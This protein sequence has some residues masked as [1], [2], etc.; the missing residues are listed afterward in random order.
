L[1][2]FLIT[3]EN[4]IIGWNEFLAALLLTSSEFIIAASF[5][6]VTDYPFSLGWSEGNRMWDYS[7]LFAKHLYDIPPGK[8]A[9]ALLDVGRQFIGGAPFIFPRITIQME[10]AWLAATIIIPY[11]LLG[12]AAFHFDRR[13]FKVWFLA[14][15]W[16]LIFLKQGPIHPPLV[17][18]A[19]MVALLWK[20]PLW[21]ALPLIVVT[22]Y[23]AW[24]SRFTWLFAPGMWI[25]MLELADAALQNK[26]LDKSAWTRALSL[27]LVGMAAGWLGPQFI[28]IIPESPINT[29]V[30]LETT[31]EMATIQ[32]LLWYR[33]LPN[34][35]YGVGIIVGLL[36]ATLPLIAILFHL[37]RT[38]KW[39]INTW[40][41][42]AIIAPLSAFL[43]V[44][45]IVSA[46]IGGG[47]DLHNM[48]MFLIGL[49]FAGA[50]AWYKGG[51]EWIQDSR[52]IHTVMKIIIVLL[53]VIPA[54][55]SL[56][57]LRSHHFGED[58]G[59]L[60]KLTDAPDE[61]S[62]GMLP[63]REAVGKALQKIQN[64]VS[65]AKQEGDVLFIDQRQ[66]LTFGYIKNVPLIPEYEKKVLINEALSSHADYFS[67]FY[68][69]LA[70][71]RFSLIVS[72]PL[73]ENIQDSA[74]S[75]GEENNAWV[76]WVSTP[77]LCYYEEKITAKDVGVQ[78]LV[79]IAEPPDC[80][81]LI[82]QENQ[83]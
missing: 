35:T 23:L 62:L 20:K 83:P 29:A 63:T 38:K 57:Q 44:G 42:L 73:H 51:R 54:L 12:L 24:A 34:A 60:I 49:T 46:K 56:R 11:L 80:T 77:I 6:D 53:L 33:L 5:I 26:Q 7:L 50:L 9:E 64:E 41:R 18:C 58:T 71:R 79:P 66:L 72:Q 17:L 47:G 10:R 4:K 67:S 68:A 59:W 45:L 36:I 55:T 16:M 25:G 14:S 82:P 48:D 61:K 43:A 15:L 19:A 21:I 65:R 2:A 3:K 28:K 81:D 30:T 31:S 8:N 52:A 40:Q 39:A 27:G 32:S 76:K 78:L 70:A 69:D 22:S 74:D 75:F 1:F 13:N 37:A